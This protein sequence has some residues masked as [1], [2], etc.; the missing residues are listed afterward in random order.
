MELNNQT[1]EKLQLRLTRAALERLIGN[2]Y[3]MEVIMSHAAVKQVID[4]HLGPLSL[5]ISE[6]ANSVPKVT[7]EVAAMIST[8]VKQEVARILREDNQALLHMVQDEVQSQI[9]PAVKTAV[10]DARRLL[11]KKLQET[12]V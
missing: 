1:E 9:E 4:R 8:V 6:F 3:Q 11:I 10:A 7:T 12:Q 2:D 5:A